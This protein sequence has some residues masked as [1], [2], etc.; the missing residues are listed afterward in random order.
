M[1]MERVWQF[2]VGRLSNSDNSC[3][4]GTSVSRHFCELIKRESE[5]IASAR[6]KGAFSFSCMHKKRLTKWK[7][8]NKWL[9]KDDSAKS[10]G[11]YNHSNVIRI[12]CELLGVG[13]C[14]VLRV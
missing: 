14:P 9:H 2:L 3:T 5:C 4:G 13:T 1:E 7:V 12:E 10:N 6:W 11:F 8:K